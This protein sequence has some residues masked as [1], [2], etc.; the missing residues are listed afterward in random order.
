MIFTFDLWMSCGGFDS[1]TLMVKY[2][3]S[4]WEPCHITINIFEVHE[5]FGVAMDL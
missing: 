3:N 4:K 2:I 5:I 1:F